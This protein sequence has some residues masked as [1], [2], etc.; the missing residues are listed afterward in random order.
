M[1]FFMRQTGQM[2]LARVVINRRERAI[3][4]TPM[5]KGRV[6]Y[7]L[8]EQRDLNSASDVFDKLPDAIPDP[9][10]IKL[11][12]QLIERQAGN[13]TLLTLK[14]FTGGYSRQTQGRGHR[15]H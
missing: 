9:E 12:V 11:A 10:M 3:G 14:T 2:A 1:A 15:D 6:A 4:I 8:H 13:M 7:T 5:G